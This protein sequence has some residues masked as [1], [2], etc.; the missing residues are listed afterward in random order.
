MTE[1]ARLAAMFDPRGPFA[2]EAPAPGGSPGPGW[3]F[4]RHS[5]R[6]LP[7]IPGYGAPEALEAP[8]DVDEPPPPVP[9]R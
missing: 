1:L 6:W 4:G 8:V 3:W 5:Q 2:E 9:S 7:P